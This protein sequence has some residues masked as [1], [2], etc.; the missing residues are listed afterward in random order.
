MLNFVRHQNKKIIYLDFRRLSEAEML[1]KVNAFR[2]LVLQLGDAGNR[3]L[4]FL[5][6]F[7][8]ESVPPSVAKTVIEM[9]K[10]TKSFI[11]RGAIISDV[12]IAKRIL[13]KTYTAI[14]GGRRKFFQTEE[15]AKDWLVSD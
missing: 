8:N 12:N 9:S 3:D 2:D 6:N 10:T 15:E 4:L 5:A 7:Q 13:M 14:T 1:E 11:R